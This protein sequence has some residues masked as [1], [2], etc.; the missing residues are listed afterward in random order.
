MTERTARELYLRIF[1]VAFEVNQ[2]DAEM[3]G[4]NAVNGVYCADDARLLPGVLREEL[5]FEG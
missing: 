5:G 2:P 1:E 3:T 4:Y